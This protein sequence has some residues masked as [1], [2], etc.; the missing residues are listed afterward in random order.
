[1]SK[2]NFQIRSSFEAY[3][4]LKH[5]NYV[6]SNAYMS[7]ITGTSV[8]LAYRDS[9]VA[10]LRDN[11]PS[12]RYPGHWDFLGGEVELGEDP[13]DAG[14]REVEEETGLI[15]ERRHIIWEKDYPFE[16]RPGAAK[17]LVARLAL[18]AA[19]QLGDEGQAVRLMSIE[20][21]LGI[22]NVVP[23]QQQRLQDYLTATE[24]LDAA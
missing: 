2:V 11:K 6:Y 24:N 10:L 15:I 14:I 8:C 5:N 23:A 19:L 13:V 18:C 20:E 4:T 12:L 21:F 3:Q 7:E 22:P 1:M 17:F 9:V 16:F